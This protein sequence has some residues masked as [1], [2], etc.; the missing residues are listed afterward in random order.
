MY[1]SQQR[2]M[3]EPRTYGL[4]HT[5]MK[6]QTPL[7]RKRRLTSIGWWGLEEESRRIGHS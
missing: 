1:I 4:L 5:M 6:R 7:W 3:G 2:G